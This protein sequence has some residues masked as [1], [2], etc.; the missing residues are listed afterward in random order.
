VDYNTRLTSNV[1]VVLHKPKSAE[2]IGAAARIC[3]NMGINQMIVVGDSRPNHEAM[4]KMATHKAVHL[5]DG[6]HYCRTLAEALAPFSLIIATTGR[7]GRKRT[8]GHPP[9]DIFTTVVPRLKNNPTA[10]VFGPEDR[11]LTNDELKY[12][13]FVSCIPTADF[14]SLNLAQAVAIHCYELSCTLRS[15]NRET[16]PEPRYASSHQLET[17][18]EH[19][20]EALITIDFLDGVN[21][22]HWMHSIRRLFG[23]LQ[24][25]EKDAT[26]IRGICRKFLWHQNNK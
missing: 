21:H 12:S 3:T 15:H 11:G 16:V 19:L 14:G 13:H 10:L 26:I 8:S 23:K 18:Y 9:R 20:E 1:A 6:I 17:M 7:Q 24:L 4:A 22:H 2:N 5:V 25:T